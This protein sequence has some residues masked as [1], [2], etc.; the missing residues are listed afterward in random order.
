[1]HRDRLHITVQLCWRRTGTVERTSETA[2]R[3][4]IPLVH[5]DLVGGEYGRD[6]EPRPPLSRALRGRYDNGSNRRAAAV[7]PVRAT[8]GTAARPRL[9]SVHNIFCLL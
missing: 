5:G 6:N 3:S 4:A 1:M 7:V 8:G 9:S 2:D